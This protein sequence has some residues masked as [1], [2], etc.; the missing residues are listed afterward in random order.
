HR[1]T[2]GYAQIIRP[3][4]LNVMTAGRGIAHSEESP[5]NRPPILHGAQLWI[6][7]PDAE[8]HC[9]PA[10]D[11]H[12][13][14]PIVERDG[15]TTTVLAG[16]ALGERSPAKIYTP[17]VGIDL[18]MP[19]AAAA[20]F[21]LRPEFEHGV[22]VL[23][24]DVLIEDARLAIGTFLYLGCGRDTLKLRAAGA[25]RVLLIGG[26]PFGEEVLLWWNFVARTKQEI[27]TARTDWESSRYFGDVHGYPG[28]R[29]AAPAL[30]WPA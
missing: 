26:V 29:L 13:V 28:Q 3:G 20:A 21:P 25:A 24:G 5:A 10:F 12:P 11:H 17:L 22:L 16:E 15:V 1:D 30:P 9:D 4:Q 8:R 18:A 27:I 6:A 19:E 2:L 14:L 23:E 7:L